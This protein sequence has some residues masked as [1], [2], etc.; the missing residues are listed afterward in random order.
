[1]QA[2]DNEWWVKTERGGRTA[3][4]ANVYG[5]GS[6]T[7]MCRKCGM[8]GVHEPFNGA[9]RLQFWIRF[10]PSPGQQPPIRLVVGNPDLEKYCYSQPRLDRD[11]SP[12][13]Y[14]EQGWLKY[15]VSIDQMDCP[16]VYQLSQV[17]FSLE[18]YDQAGFCIS[19][20][21]IIK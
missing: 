17:T 15:D 16:D 10:D 20:L 6:I 13:E 5:G 1:M 7:F 4:C 19:E 11:V 3:G 8:D 18:D 12:V 14:G 21:R 2:I 9:K